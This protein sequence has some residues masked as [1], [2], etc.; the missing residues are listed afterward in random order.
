MTVDVVSRLMIAYLAGIGNF[1][2]QRAFV[3]ARSGDAGIRRLEYSGLGVTLIAWT[4]PAGL[5]RFQSLGSCE[6]VLNNC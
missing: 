6:E 2:L 1:E 5:C 3:G 4:Q